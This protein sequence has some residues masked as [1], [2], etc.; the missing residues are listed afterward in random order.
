MKTVR[1][2]SLMDLDSIT[3]FSEI[4]ILFS[5]FEKVKVIK[6]TKEISVIHGKGYEKIKKIIK[7]QGDLH[8]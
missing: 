5:L 7:V 8:A 4:G 6:S 3:M 1:I 2:S